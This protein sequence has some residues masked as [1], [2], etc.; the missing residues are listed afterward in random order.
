MK[1]IGIIGYGTFTNLMLKVFEE[2]MPKVKVKVYS[3]S[4]EIDNEIIFS[5]EEVAE[6]DFIIPSVPISAFENTIID[7]VPHLK[8]GTTIIDICS[9]MVHPRNVMLKHLPKEINIICTHPNFGP[10]SY[11]LNGNSVKGLNFIIDYVRATSHAQNI[12]DSF[13][14]MLEVNIIKLTAEEHDE[15]VGVPHFVSMFQGILVNELGLKRTEFGAASTQRM[16]DMAEGVGKD[17][18]ILRDM[19]HYNPFCKEYLGSI[20]FSTKLITD[21]VFGE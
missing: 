16:F 11:R 2:Y 5:F 15:Q 6:C 9:V 8:S 20:N 12:F 4:Q 18:Q 3:R 7:L 19:Y 10:E 1:T 17:I 21:R 13:L 14:K